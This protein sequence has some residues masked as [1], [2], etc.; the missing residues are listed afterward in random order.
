MRVDKINVLQIFIGL[1]LNV[2]A[3]FI[4]IATNT[5]PFA[6][7]TM[8]AWY[9]SLTIVSF[10]RDNQIINS[11]ILSRLWNNDLCSCIHSILL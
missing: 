3:I 2:I 4:Q 8:S 11:I 10:F 1:L 6:L 5:F 9:Y 7:F